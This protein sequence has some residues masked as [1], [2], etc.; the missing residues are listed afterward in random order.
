M[1]KRLILVCLVVIFSIL[2][3]FQQYSQRDS[4]TIIIN[5]F[6]NMFTKVEIKDDGSIYVDQSINCSM[7]D[8]PE[9]K[10]EIRFE[11]P[12]Y[13]TY[14]CGVGLESN[15]F[16]ILNTNIE[17]ESGFKF[18]YKEFYWSIIID[19]NQIDEFNNLLKNNNNV[20]N[21]NYT[22]KSSSVLAH[23]EKKST[24]I[25]ALRNNNRFSNSNIMDISYPSFM[26]LKENNDRILKNENNHIEVDLK[27]NYRLIEELKFDDEFLG[28]YS[29]KAYRDKTYYYQVE[30]VFVIVIAIFSL[31]LIV[32]V[33]I[34]Y[35]KRTVK[36]VKGKY[37]RDTKELIS[38]ILAESIIDG[39]IDAKDLI[40]T[41]IVDLIRKGNLELNDND[42]T[43]T[44]LSYEDLNNVEKDVIRIVFFPF[45]NQIEPINVLV[46]KTIKISEI[47]NVFKKSTSHTLQIFD[48]FDTIKFNIKKELMKNGICSLIWNT[49]L[50][51]VRNLS[52]VLILN[53]AFF[54]ALGNTLCYSGFNAF[55]L[56]SIIIIDLILYVL[57]NKYSVNEMI[58]K[59]LGLTSLF[60]FLTIIGLVTRFAE[61]EFE[62]IPLLSFIILLFIN[63]LI[64][65][66][67]NIY[68]FT[69]KG[70]QEF[71]KVF[72]LKS[73]LIDYSLIE[74]RDID[75]VAVFDEYLSYATAFGIPSNITKRFNELMMNANI[76]MQII[77]KILSF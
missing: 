30:R 63:I 33:I 35:A 74:Q 14:R 34:A 29:V 10:Y 51:Q 5:N 8:N 58:E 25:F 54:Y 18:N 72:G 9:K 20:V 41:V 70:K 11:Y 64:I 55:M 52:S 24:V 75:G 71:I 15:F 16:E 76:R 69:G 53:T 1:K 7:L 23:N 48:I 40:M 19:S 77:L 50:K 67:S 21:F 61:Y 31:L 13:I 68:V 59:E 66:T 2:T 36:V 45:N 32:V 62:L 73:Y 12:V 28:K 22:L 39:K 43:I 3:F 26:K 56:F 37:Y 65:K 17:K 42:D 49:I 6:D 60:M 57:L 4:D 44:L 47:S 27:T 38:P 46:G